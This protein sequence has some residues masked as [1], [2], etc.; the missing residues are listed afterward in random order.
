[1]CLK[2]T[3]QIWPLGQA[4]KTPPFHGG[5]T[6]SSPVGVTIFMQVRLGRVAKRLNAA[7]CKSA[8]LRVQGFE[9]LPYHHY[10]YI[11]SLGYS[12][13]VRQRTLTPSSRWFESSYPSHTNVYRLFGRRFFMRT[14]PYGFADASS[15]CELF[16]C[17]KQVPGKNL[18]GKLKSEPHVLHANPKELCENP[19]IYYRT[20]LQTNRTLFL[21]NE[22][23]VA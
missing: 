14:I 2:E 18:L 4:V 20:S 7:D 8:P 6:G 21:F 10:F 15:N 19:N 17:P 13:A 22:R 9:S 5:N 12:Q 11:L 1:M 3:F 16:Q 23:A